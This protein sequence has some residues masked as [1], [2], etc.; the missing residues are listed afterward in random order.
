MESLSHFQRWLSIFWNPSKAEKSRAAQPEVRGL[1]SIQ[2]KRKTGARW[3]RPS[4]G[5]EH[6][7]IKREIKVRPQKLYPVLFLMAH[8]VC[9]DHISALKGDFYQRLLRSF[10][11]DLGANLK[12]SQ[13][14]K[15]GIIQASRK[16]KTAMGWRQI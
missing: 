12:S 7:W 11:K 9:W 14:P 4:L 5:R 16:I 3:E 8:F 6:I 15:D 10:P 13:R 2:V 1:W